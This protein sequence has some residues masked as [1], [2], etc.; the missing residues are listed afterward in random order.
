MLLLPAPLLRTL[1]W[2][3]S[4]LGY[5]RVLGEAPQVVGQVSQC[6]LSNLA[7]TTAIAARD[8]TSRC[9]LY[10][11]ESALGLPCAAHGMLQ[12]HVGGNCCMIGREWRPCCGLHVRV[13]TLPATSLQM[14]AGVAGLRFCVARGA[15]GEGG[16]GAAAGAAAGATTTAAAPPPPLN[17][18]VQLSDSMAAIG[19]AEW[20]AC[21]LGGGEVNPFLSWDFLD[22]LEASGSAVKEQGW[23]PQHLLVR[24]DAS[25]ELLG[26][27]PLYL[28]GHSYGEYVFDSSWASAY[29]RYIGKQ[30]YP[31]LQSC[32]PFTP[33]TGPVSGGSA[34]AALGCRVTPRPSSAHPASFKH[35]T[36]CL[37]NLSLAAAPADQGGIALGGRRAPRDGR[38]A[39][40]RC[41]A[42]GR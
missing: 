8:L 4:L 9:V 34:G 12:T 22:V 39:D 31:K 32:V 20:D 5:C 7:T 6:T 42:A 2:L 10:G 41:Q 27:C 15:S 26:C 28:K 23:L 36:L 14:R 40:R 13:S 33:V 17:L 21:A 11:D 30:Y 24:D 37:P 3:A 19:Q 38:H 25:G 16:P 18:R 1:I 29:E 35:S